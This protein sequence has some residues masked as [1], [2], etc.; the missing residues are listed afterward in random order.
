MQNIPNAGR[1]ENLSRKKRISYAFLEIL[2]TILI[3]LAFYFAVDAV[4]DRG[5]FIV[6]WNRRCAGGSVFVNK[7]AYRWGHVVRGDIVTIY[8]P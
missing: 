8:S 4:I 2:Q 3:A 5:G 7:L 1:H 6:A